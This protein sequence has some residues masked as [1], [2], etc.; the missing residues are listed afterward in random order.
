METTLTQTPSP[1]A[2]G[3][4]QSTPPPASVDYRTFFD[5]KGTITKPEDFFKSIEGAEHLAKRFTSVG[6]LAKSY[7]N[8]E[9]QLSNGNKI[10]VPNENSTPEEWDAFFS[11]TGRPEKPEDYGIKHPEKIGE[12]DFPKE[13]WSEEEAKEFSTFAHKL[14]LSKKSASALAEWQATK[15]GKAWQSQQQAQNAEKEAAIGALKKE[16]GVSYNDRLTL[17]K[18]AALHLGGEE[19]LS[20]KLASDPAFI[21]AMA[22]AGESFAEGKLPNLRAPGMFG[23][24]PKK[25]ITDIRGD[26]A[27]PYNNPKHPGHEQAVKDMTL[28]YQKAFP[29]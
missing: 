21:R 2:E 17:A 3:Q 10:A 18:Q 25:Q 24:D 26:K 23:G 29:E 4:S 27:H 7:V 8:A 11:K 19:L 9:R 20:H 5:E 28:L 22:K 13:I 15:I 14:G 1:G 12:S 16:W 6:A